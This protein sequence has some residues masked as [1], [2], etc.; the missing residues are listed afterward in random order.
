MKINGK[1]LFKIASYA[2]VAAAVVYFFRSF[3]LRLDDIPHIEW[4][5]R[6]LAAVVFSV[7]G[8]LFTNILTGYV[9]RIQLKDHGVKLRPGKSIQIMLISQFGKY[10]PGNVG[11]FAGRA[12]LGTS[13]G[14]PVAVSMNTIMVDVLWHLAIGSTFAALAAYFYSDTLRELLPSHLEAPH[15]LAITGLLM[16]IPWIGI[17][18]MNKLMP[19]LSRKIGKGEL[20]ATPSLRTALLV[21]ALILVGFHT[22]GAIVKL[23]AAWLFHVPQ[24]EYYMITVLYIASW[25]VGYVV[26]GAP[27]GVGVREAV[28]VLLL[29]PIVGEGAAVGLGISMRLTNMLGDAVAFGL[30][31]FSRR[32]L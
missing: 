5:A 12:A 29:S 20:I 19:G 17:T 24:G 18:V 3:Y 2:V 7:L 21:S 28:M 23:Q 11:H 16:F 31:M 9:W 25:T 30:G 6:S 14:V 8:I 26:P 10:L 15:L 27:G 13:A 22:L 1:L 32:F 4:N